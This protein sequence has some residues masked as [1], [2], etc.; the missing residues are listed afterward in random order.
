MKLNE[1]AQGTD[2]AKKSLEEVVKT[3]KG[4]PFNLG[5]QVR[6]FAMWRRCFFGDSC[7]LYF[8]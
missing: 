7:G 4:K 3:E 6:L 8:R 2:L 5:A 1:L